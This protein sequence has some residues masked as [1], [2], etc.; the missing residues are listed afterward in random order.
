M[1]LQTLI[2]RLQEIVDINPEA[3]EHEI[4]YF[5]EQ[6]DKYLPVEWV[7]IGWFE[8]KEGYFLEQM[9]FEEWQEECNK[10]EKLNAIFLS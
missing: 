10:K 6:R 2:E 9:E 7:S 3:K 4:V 8:P 1:N 5:S